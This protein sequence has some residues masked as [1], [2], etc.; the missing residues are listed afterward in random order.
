MISPI[1]THISLILV[2]KKKQL[3]DVFEQKKD[4]INSQ[5]QMPRSH[6]IMAQFPISQAPDPGI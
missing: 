2:L 1:E 3:S 6:A 4:W 5:K